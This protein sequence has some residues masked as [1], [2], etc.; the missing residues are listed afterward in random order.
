M[1]DV[2]G[3]LVLCGGSCIVG[4]TLAIAVMRRKREHEVELL[5]RLSRRLENRAEKADTAE[6]KIAYVIAR[7]ELIR[8]MRTIENGD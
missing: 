4:Y 7:G 1:T 5:R 8:T 3:F 2:L 6:R